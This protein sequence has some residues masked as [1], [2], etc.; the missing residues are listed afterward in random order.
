MIKRRLVP[1][2]LAASIGIAQFGALPALAQVS[3]TL[4]LNVATAAPAEARNT[5]RLTLAFGRADRS[6]T[7]NA[8]SV[9]APALAAHDIMINT[10]DGQAA[11]FIIHS[12]SAPS[13]NE[14]V[15]NIEYFGFEPLDASDSFTVSVLAPDDVAAE[16]ASAA[17]DF[18]PPS[19]PT[20]DG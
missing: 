6:P 20:S 13:G 9:H 4:A 19:L 7:A 3:P 11:P 12:V 5:W 10:A 14:L 17:F 1:A 18:L 16:R 15:L 2:F 8:R